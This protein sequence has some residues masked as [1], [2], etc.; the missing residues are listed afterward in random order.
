[1][2]EEYILITG[3]VKRIGLDLAK[4]F[5]SENKNIIVSYNISTNGINELNKIAEDKSLSVKTIKCDLSIQNN[6]YNLIKSATLIGNV[7]LIIHCASIIKEDD[8]LSC[9]KN[10]SESINIH[11]MFL[12]EIGRF[13]KENNFCC[14]I[15]SF[16]DANLTHRTKYLSYDIGKKISEDVMKYLSFQLKGLSRVN[17]I[18]PTWVENYDFV[19]KNKSGESKKYF[20]KIKLSD[21]LCDIE[22]I[23][24]TVK[25]IMQNKSLNGEIIRLSSGTSVI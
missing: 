20:D 2:N 13:I 25:F 24:N 8:I 11:G 19:I 15:I 16:S 12:L 4:F 17:L 6:G 22:Q 18:A 14:D 5:L 7:K 23:K 10:I 1:M 21:C 3:G 9:Y